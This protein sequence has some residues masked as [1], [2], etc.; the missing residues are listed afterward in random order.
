[1][2]N[3]ELPFF[4]LLIGAVVILGGFVCFK[5]WSCQHDHTMVQIDGE[6][7]FINWDKVRKEANDPTGTD[8]TRG[9]AKSLLAVKN[10]T[11][12]DPNRP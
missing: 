4:L 1:M 7:V 6:K 3:K 2:T 11:W 9:V 5:T 12:I 10:N 8:L